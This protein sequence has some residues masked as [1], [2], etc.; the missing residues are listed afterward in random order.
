MSEE[1][2][3]EQPQEATAITI[4]TLQVR[5][6][7]LRGFVDLTIHDVDLDLWLLGPVPSHLVA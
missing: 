2:I 5:K 7:R 4:P 6:W 1:W 3:N